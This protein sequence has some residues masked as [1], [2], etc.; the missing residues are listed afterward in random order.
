MK[1]FV[2]F[3]VAVLCCVGAAAQNNLVYEP[4][5]LTIDKADGQ[6]AI[7]E[8]VNVYG[9]LKGNVAADLVCVVEANGKCIQRPVMVELNED[10][11]TLLFSSSFDKPTAAQVYVFPKG[12]ENLKAAV[13]FVAGAEGFRPGFEAPKDFDKFWKKQ[14]KTLRKCRMTP[15]LTP[16]EFPEKAKRYESKC[17][18]YAL[19]VNMPQGRPVH[20]YIAWPKNAQPS[21]LPIVIC[22]HGAGY[23]RSNAVNAARW[24]SKGVI[25]IDLNA[26]GY[27][28]DQ[29]DEYY[30]SIGKGELKDY[31][32]RKVTDH[33]SFYFRLMYLRAVRAIDYA[34]TLPIWDGKRIL[35]IGGSQGGAQSIA[36]AAI[37]KRVGAVCAHVP[38]VTD[39]AGHLHG[40]RGG[41][42]YYDRQMKKKDNLDAEMAVLPYYDGAI[43]LQ[44]TD[45]KLWIEA[46]LIDTVCPPECV[47]AAFN[48]AVS[49]DK[50]LYTFPYRPHSSS[51]IDSR[52]ED[53]WDDMIDDPRDEEIMQWL[54]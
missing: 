2:V 21:S 6:Y 25:A 10:G 34:A 46:G 35:A 29:P 23:S 19:T 44:H 52:F 39:M 18:L 36:V 8:T 3:F 12:D 15:E 1:R 31:R 27:P 37:D 13:G 20:A 33:D 26:H 24:A 11:K 38:A 49:P 22:P 32:S 28:D 53:G 50:K 30:K 48:V 4:V 47:I 43:M 7:G 40:H 45:A 54:K 14:L 51:K 17:E 16:A 5:V 42:P 41:W 9:Q